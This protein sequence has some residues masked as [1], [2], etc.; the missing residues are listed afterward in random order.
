MTADGPTFADLER[1][2]SQE[3]VQ[4]KGDK[5]P[6]EE[7][8]DHVRHIPI[9]RMSAGDLAKACRQNVWIEQVVPVAIEVLKN[10]PQAGE[11]YD[12]E[13]VVALKFVPAG[14]W[15]Q[16][17][18]LARALRAIVEPALRDFDQQVQGDANELL[19]RLTAAVL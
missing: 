10:S 2:T 4:G 14:F 5:W 16:H 1:A 13:M 6:L 12:G 9:K 3:Y 7:W 19:S 17:A 8:Y 15:L 18:D 11:L